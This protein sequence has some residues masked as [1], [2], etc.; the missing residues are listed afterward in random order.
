MQDAG[1]TIVIRDFA[2]RDIDEVIECAKESFVEELE[3]EGFDQDNWRRLV[4][5]RFSI[6]GR[7]LLGCLKLL[8][9]EPLKFFVADVDGKAV[10]TTMVT[11]LRNIGYIQLVMI[12]PNFR[13]K[14]I[15]SE[16]MKSAIQYIQKRKLAKA[17][18]HVSA[19]NDP[20]KK[21]Y[22][23]LGFK[24]FEETV[25]LTADVDSLSGFE[26]SGEVQIREFNKSDTDTVYD[27]IKKSRDPNTFKVYNFQKSDLRSS[28]WERRVR[29]SKS[30]KIVAVKDGNI[31]G[32][33]FLSCTSSRE[34]GRIRNIDVP[35]ETNSH[36]IEEGLVSAGV[37]FI[38]SSGTKTV[39][40]TVPPIKEVLIGRLEN[41]G[42]KKRYFTEG[43]V[44][45]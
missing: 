21:L 2:E 45:Q 29:M 33:A 23:K 3:I 16:L 34:A 6:F 13:R 38:R 25:Y 9:R 35:Q 7:V 31:V 27:L 11:K 12:H 39:L 36:E 5:W 28:F 22:D 42:F 10:G 8:D 26:S 14:G 32:Y 30:K 18:L 43:M 40:V 15:A 24:K 37:D 1:V 20:A 19:T 17:V 44:L 4:R 41:L